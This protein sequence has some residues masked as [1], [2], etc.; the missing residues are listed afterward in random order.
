MNDYTT[1]IKWGETFFTFQHV[2]LVLKNKAVSVNV[3]KACTGSRG[4]ALLI[5]HLG[6]R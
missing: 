3:M 6:T 5:L 4:I 2:L 1:G